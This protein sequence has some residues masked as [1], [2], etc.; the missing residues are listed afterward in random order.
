M[1]VVMF[2]NRVFADVIRLRWS[3]TGLKWTLFQWVLFQWISTPMTGILIRQ[4]NWVEKR[5]LC[6]RRDRHRGQ[7]ITQQQRQRWLKGKEPPGHLGGS[8]GY[9][10]DS[11][12]RL[13][14]WSHGP[15]AQAP[16]QALHWQ[17]GACLGFSL[18]LSLPLLYSCSLSF[19]L[20]LSLK[21]IHK[22]KKY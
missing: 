22:L 20:S 21:K 16:H 2:G 7:V 15:W 9:A 19:S 18:S 14:S 11:W 13:R 10:S 8:V 1:N 4:G 5:M 17:H 6:E 12:F 3:D